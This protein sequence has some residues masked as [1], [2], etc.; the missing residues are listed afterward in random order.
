MRL[1][2]GRVNTSFANSL[3]TA[4]RV[5]LARAELNVN[6]DRNQVYDKTSLPLTISNN[7]YD[8]EDYQTTL[9]SK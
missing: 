8:D 7:S 1:S 9:S 2:R 5:D 3:E 4:T 6:R